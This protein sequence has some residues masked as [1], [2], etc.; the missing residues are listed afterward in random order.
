MPASW[1]MFLCI[2]RIQLFSQVQSKGKTCLSYARTF[3]FWVIATY[4]RHPFPNLSRSEIGQVNGHWRKIGSWKT[5]VEKTAFF[6]FHSNAEQHEHSIYLSAR[7]VLRL[8]GGKIN[9]RRL[10]YRAS[11]DFS[12]ERL[13]FLS[14]SIFN[15]EIVLSWP[16][17]SLL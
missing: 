15:S 11:L 1:R 12:F 17:T 2:F 8:Q 10:N 16:Q 9:G 13:A 14:Q 4:N 6:T 7:L 5:T 3:L